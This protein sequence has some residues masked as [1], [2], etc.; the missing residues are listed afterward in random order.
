MIKSLH[1]GKRTIRIQ[2]TAWYI[3][4]LAITLILFS[5]YLYVVLEHS[6]LRQLNT[7]LQVTATQTLTNLINKD[8]HPAFH[9]TPESQEMTEQFLQAGIAVRL[10]DQ[11]GHIWDGFG[12]YSAIPIL[13]PNKNGYLDL[14]FQDKNWRVYSQKIPTSEGYTG[15]LQVAESLEPVYEAS[16]HLFNLMVLGFPLVL[17]TAGLGGW[18]LANRA[19][20]P[21]N[22]I[23]SKTQAISANNFT[24]RINYNGPPDE[25]GRLAKTIDQM[26]DR[27]QFAF[28]HERRFTADA[29]HELRTPLTVIKGRIGV[30]LSRLRSPKEYENTLQDLEREAD[31][32]IRLTN[33]LLFL[34]RLELRPIHSSFLQPVDLTNLLGALIEQMQ[35]LAASKN[36]DLTEKIAEDLWVIG[37]PDYLTNLFLNLLDNALKYTPEGGQVFLEAQKK[38]QQ[39]K[40]TVKDTG[41]GIEAKHLPYLFDRFYRVEEA[42]SRQT[43]GAGLGLAIAQ[44]I[45]RL[46]GGTL[47]V[48]SKINQGTKFSLFLPIHS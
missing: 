28:E 38:H 37:N 41:L 42:R 23:I 6:L 17:L 21:I 16:K 35:P 8:G 13:I 34:A 47:T 39:I 40:I 2:L 1:F 29:A 45:S 5:S 11:K 7:T 9:T 27:L 33:G 4:L 20:N 18:F 22:E 25:V 36:I 12:S 30:T 48:N 10:I 26:L 31:R 15:W 24:Q 14:S 44:E 46:H 19:L 32:L 43:G 3:L